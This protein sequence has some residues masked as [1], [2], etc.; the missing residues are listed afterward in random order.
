[1]LSPGRFALGALELAVVAGAAW[2]GAA[3]LRSHFVPVWRGLVA[4]IADAVIAVSL[5][6]VVAQL[7]GTFGL[8]RE[9]IVVFAVAALGVALR[10]H[11]AV[12]AT[13]KRV[14]STARTDSWRRV[15][16][17]GAVVAVAVTVG[18]WAGR[19]GSVLDGGITSFD[20]LHY[21]LPFAARFAQTGS[22]AHIQLI[23]PEFP[24]AYHHANAELL[25][26]LG[27]LFFHRD[28][29]S[30][31]LNLGFV[32]LA[33]ASAYCL[34]ERWGEGPLA[35]IGLCVVLAS[36]L[37]GLHHAG[38]ATNDVVVLAFVLAAAA[39]LVQPDGGVGSFAVVGLAAG[40]AFGT[41]L[42]AAAVA[43]VLVLAVPFV[44]RRGRRVA[45]LLWA[46]FLAAVPAA[47]WLV[48]DLVDTGSP[49]PGV[50][51]PFF[52]SASFH[53]LDDFGYSVS[54]YVTSTDVWR[55]W[56]FPGLRI[57]LGRTWPI[58]VVA[59]VIGAVFAVASGERATK[60]L[61]IATMVGGLFY[62]V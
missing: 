38:T 25:H 14:G 42:T 34:G 53:T 58:A 9:G 11:L 20:S 3:A 55:R 12:P 43:A 22:T 40:M 60:V 35:V 50:Q 5:I 59:V 24:D 26:S 32:A 30:V 51:L 61:G 15:S 28:V 4:R 46:G 13:Q 21:H 49:A 56:F 33:L 41:K 57:D 45:S 31:F 8:L 27:M 54:H 37:I 36:P 47:Y 6:V 18:Q 29:L 39:L 1:M 16:G 10:L 48:R 44:A 19:I 2:V 62:F 7:L 17:A 23:T 52:S